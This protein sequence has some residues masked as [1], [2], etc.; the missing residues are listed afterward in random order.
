ME[1]RSR[2]LV[3][4]LSFLMLGA[5]AASAEELENAS[6]AGRLSELEAELAAL[7]QQVGGNSPAPTAADGCYGRPYCCSP[8]CCEPYCPLPCCELGWYGGAEAVWAQPSL[9]FS[10]L[11]YDFEATP[12]VWLGYNGCGLGVRGHW[13]HFDGDADPLSTTAID[14]LGGGTILVTQ[15]NAREQLELDLADLEVTKR[16]SA[17]GSTFVVA[18]GARYVRYDRETTS[19]ITNTQN[20][21]P[22]TAVQ[23]AQGERLEGVGPTIAAE[24]VTPVTCN[25]SLLAGFRATIA[26][27]DEDVS[28]RVQDL[29]N[30]GAVVSDVSSQDDRIQVI[31]IDLGLQYAVG[32][33]F[34][35]G[36][37]QAQHWDEPSVFSM[38]VQGFA[39]AVGVNY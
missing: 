12:R 16:F 35:R 15:I 8:C 26:F 32:R 3:V 39:A 5:A 13:W 18:A 23:V 27:G 36:G 22:L 37:W 38:G 30:G 21:D 31:E 11:E 28:V 1:V 33:W 6:V 14:D 20:G 4:A 25:W 17:C 19:T 10:E 9:H 34:V 7:R 2:C 24:I 29:L